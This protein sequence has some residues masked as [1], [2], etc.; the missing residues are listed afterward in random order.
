MQL[1]RAN[2]WSLAFADLS[3]LMLGFIALSFVHPVPAPDNQSAGDEE[4]SPPSENFEWKTAILFEPGEAMLTTAGK[5]KAKQVAGMIKQRPVQISLSVAGRA[6]ASARL[7][8]WEL[9]AAR[10][11]AFARALKAAGVDETAIVMGGQNRVMTNEPQSL[12]I[13][14]THDADL[15]APANGTALASQISN[16]LEE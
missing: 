1:G 6:S 3:L 11:A 13:A 7:D 16:N 12:I 2:R 15:V 8:Q 4:V 5:E 9:S 10:M 14:I